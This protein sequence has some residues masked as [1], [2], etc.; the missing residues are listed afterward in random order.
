MVASDAEKAFDFSP[1]PIAL[2]SLDGVLLGC[3]SRFQRTIG[4]ASILRG[5][6]FLKNC[7]H[8][9]EHTRFR[10]AMARALEAREKVDASNDDKASDIQEWMRVPV[11]RNCRTLAL[12]SKGEY[13]IWRRLDWALSNIDDFTLCL[14]A[15]FSN[16][17]LVDE[18][19]MEHDGQPSER[20]LLDF[21]NKAPIAMHWLS[22]TGHVLWANETE[23]N[24]LG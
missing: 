16:G 15:R 8:N 6:D 5:L 13:P 23:M 3:N 12:G 18:K 19:E 24:T 9:E 10:V 4:S 20:E 21:L 17:P 11:V 22:G 7:V 14:T 1:D 2:V